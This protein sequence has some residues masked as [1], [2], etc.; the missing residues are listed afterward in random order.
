MITECQG[1]P[2]ILFRPVDAFVHLLSHLKNSEAD[3]VLGLFPTNPLQ[4]TD[5]DMVEIKEN[6]TVASLTNGKAYSKV[7]GTPGVACTTR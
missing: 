5:M 3:V 7:Y 1:F 4:R 6:H 2:D